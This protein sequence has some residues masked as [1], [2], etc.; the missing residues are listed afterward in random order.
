MIGWH[1]VL[2]LLTDEMRGDGVL[3]GWQPLKPSRPGADDS[4]IQLSMPRLVLFRRADGSVPPAMEL[5]AGSTQVYGFESFQV[6][7]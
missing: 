1:R 7:R 3:H 5:G 6:V 4:V 2:E